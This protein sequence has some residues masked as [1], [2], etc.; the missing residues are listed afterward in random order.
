MKRKN[1]KNILRA[2]LLTLCVLF[3]LFCAPQHIA[4]AQT[5]ADFEPLVYPAEA[6][7]DF[8]EEMLDRVSTGPDYVSNRGYEES[9]L[10]MSP[11]WSCTVSGAEI[12]VYAVMS[13]NED[14]NRG[15]LQ[16]FATVYVVDFADGLDV[17]LTATDK[18]IGSAVILPAKY[19]AVADVNQNRVRFTATA[20]GAYTCLVNGDSLTDAV[21]VFV[22]EYTDEEAQINLYKEQYG[23]DRVKVF[24][25]GFYEVEYIDT[26]NCDVIYFCRGSYVCAKHLYDVRGDEEAAALPPRKT[27]LDIYE[28][29]GFIIDGAGTVD[30]NRLDRNE[31]SL[32]NV[33][34]GK[35]CSFTGLTFINPPVW[36]V[37][38]Y[39]TADSTIDDFTI[40]GYRTNSDGINI[41]GCINMEIKDCF[42]RNGDDCYSVKT[43][44]A[45]Y[46]AENIT[47]RN[48]IGWSNKC[49]CFG[50]TG[51]VYAPIEN[52]TFTD[53]DVLYRNANWDNDRVASLTVAVEM[54]GAPINNV[55][56]E[57]IN[58]YRDDGRPFYCIINNE[59]ENC[60]VSGVVFRNVTYNAAEQAKIATRKSFDDFTEKFCAFV[61]RMLR[62]LFPGLEENFRSL[63]PGNNEMDVK[64]ENV[65][66]NGNELNNFNWKFFVE[67]KRN[68]NISF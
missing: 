52:I 59:I 21:T 36:T 34:H 20:T 67:S 29:D 6:V 63:I 9:G 31:R 37:T 41:C 27:F 33:S 2:A 8:R 15:V 49:R 11:Y 39:A 32:M 65:V 4:S 45:E 53:C 14:Q 64:L 47:F 66:A 17:T 68:E 7:T 40:F 54:G 18:Q 42:A 62:F 57:N 48:C 13:Y 25:A 61:Y 38:V 28:R 1:N 55:L 51:E 50:I 56:F 26:E 58:I 43:M 35:N 19:G 12:P 60:K 5:A 46:T 22:K 44:N 10:Y 24:P 16:S 23:A 30:F 3:S